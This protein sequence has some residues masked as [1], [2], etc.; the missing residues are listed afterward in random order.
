MRDRVKGRLVEESAATIT[1]T[2][3]RRRKLALDEEADELQEPSLTSK[4][5][6]K[7]TVAAE[8]VEEAVESKAKLQDAQG[9]ASA[10]KVLSCVDEA[11]GKC[12]LIQIGGDETIGR[13]LTRVR[14]YGKANNIIGGRIDG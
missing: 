13:G 4:R 7:R 3:P 2:S 8:S 12:A 6:K 11:L 9:N 1:R 14:R 5:S 10:T